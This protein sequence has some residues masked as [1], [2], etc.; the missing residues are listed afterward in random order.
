[1]L[2]DFTG[3]LTTSPFPAIGSLGD[4]AGVDP[5]VVLELMMGD[6]TADTDHPWHRLE[7]GE[8][9]IL[10]YAVERARK[11]GYVESGDRVVMIAGTGLRVSQHNMI[12]VHEID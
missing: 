2:I 6:Y 3:V 12:V 9:T 5:E 7:R 1:M 8:I 4:E 11:I 10:D